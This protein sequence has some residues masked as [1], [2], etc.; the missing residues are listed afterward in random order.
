ML[1]VSYLNNYYNHKRNNQANAINA[2]KYI[3]P[4]GNKKSYLKYETT[5]NER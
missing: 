5:E 2:T 1:Y 4:Y 3:G